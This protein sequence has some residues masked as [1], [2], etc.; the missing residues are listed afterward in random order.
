MPPNI[1]LPILGKN[2]NMISRISHQLPFKIRPLAILLTPPTN[3][4]V[5]RGGSLKGKGAVPFGGESIDSRLLSCEVMV[6]A[7]GA[8]N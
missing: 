6:G 2:R 1:L 5:G 8:G 4:S 7:A 3:S